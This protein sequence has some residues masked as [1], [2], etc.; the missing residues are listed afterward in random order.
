MYSVMLAREGNGREI[1]GKAA[2]FSAFDRTI[3]R[4]DGSEN[5]SRLYY[6]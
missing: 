1:E 2:R 4:K 5:H 6:N 3:D